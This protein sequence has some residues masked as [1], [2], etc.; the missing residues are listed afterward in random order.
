VER[1]VVLKKIIFIILAV[2]LFF[3]LL[4][5]GSRIEDML[6]DHLPFLLK[7][8]PLLFEESAY[9][10]ALPIPSS[11]SQP[12]RHNSLGF[13]SQE[14]S[15]KKIP[16]GYR[17]FCLGGSDTYGTNLTNDQTWPAQ[18]EEALNSYQKERHFEVINAAVPGYT[19]M[20]GAINLITRILPLEPDMVILYQ[21]YND[22]KPNRY[23]GFKPDYTHWRTRDRMPKKHLLSILA[24]KS[25]FVRNSWNLYRRIIKRFN[26]SGRFNLQIR[27]LK[28]YDTASQEGVDAFK[29][30][31]LTMVYVCRG[32]GIRPV[33]STFATTLNE[34]NLQESPEKFEVLTDYVSTLTYKGLLDAKKRYNDAI[35]EVAAEEDVLLVDNNALVPETFDY[36]YDYCHFTPEG[37]RLV[38][39]NFAKEILSSLKQ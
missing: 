3:S 39:D 26:S 1:K 31:I 21:G 14:F 9:L 34:R 10:P 4:E 27:G 30:N 32:Y 37:A 35:R 13:R 8:A 33:L 11:Q 36:L 15:A 18:L 17:I 23:P 20:E 6:F 2:I 5:T 29:R 24:L 7:K 38:A 28:S 19:T 16:G 22:F 12:Y 25:S